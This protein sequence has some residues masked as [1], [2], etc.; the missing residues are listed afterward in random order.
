MNAKLLSRQG[1][2]N[3][4]LRGGVNAVVG[5]AGVNSG[6]GFGGFGG[7]CDQRERAGD[8][9]DREPGDDGEIHTMKN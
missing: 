3:K 6:A 9:D 1:E 7:R 4:P 5:V 8:D 2:K